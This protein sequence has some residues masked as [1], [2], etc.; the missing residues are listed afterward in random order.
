MTSNQVCELVSGLRSRHA[1][2]RHKAIR[3]LLHF[4]KTDLREMSPE[5][6]TQ[7]LDDFNQQIHALTSSYDNNE[8]KAGILAI[9]VYLIGYIALI[10]N[11]IIKH[12]IS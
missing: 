10:T 11:Y 9:G 12:S 4:T 3:E 7:V 2:T 5:V 8:K 1:E 6:L